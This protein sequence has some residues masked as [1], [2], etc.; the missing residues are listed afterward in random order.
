MLRN[1]CVVAPIFSIW[2]SGLGGTN[3]NVAATATAVGTA[4]AAATT[5]VDVNV[6]SRNTK[7]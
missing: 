4:T 1:G 7:P 5:A 6:G 3:E 2:I